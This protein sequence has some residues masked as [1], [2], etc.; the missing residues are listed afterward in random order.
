M[1]ICPPP[2]DWKRMRG[3]VGGGGQGRDAGVIGKPGLVL[4][5]QGFASVLLWSG[6]GHTVRLQG[7][8]F[9]R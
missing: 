6:V 9:M 5:W 7:R 4:Q 1:L 3:V 8:G 2:L